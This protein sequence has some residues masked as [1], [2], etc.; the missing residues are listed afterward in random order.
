MSLHLHVSNWPTS[1]S[2]MHHVSS[3][4]LLLPIV[5]LPLSGTVSLSHNVP[6]RVPY[7][8]PYLSVIR[9]IAWSVRTCSAPSRCQ[10]SFHQKRRPAW[11]TE[12]HELLLQ[13]EFSEFPGTWVVE[14]LE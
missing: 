11:T 4:I 6:F 7:A 12:I 14:W 8:M 5:H 10:S 3:F 1:L 13:A 2:F 9:I